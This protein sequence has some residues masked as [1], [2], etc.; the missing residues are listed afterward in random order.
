MELDALNEDFGLKVWYSQI[1]IP[2]LH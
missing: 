1:I 2:I